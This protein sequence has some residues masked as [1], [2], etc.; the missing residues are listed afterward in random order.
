MSHNN[1]IDSGGRNTIAS[2]YKQVD[3]V[4]SRYVDH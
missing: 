4:L 2:V 1:E 3:A